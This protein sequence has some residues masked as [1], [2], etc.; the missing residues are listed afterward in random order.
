[1]DLLNKRFSCEHCV[2][3][4]AEAQHKMS[5][6]HHGRKLGFVAGFMA[7]RFEFASE[8]LPHLVSSKAAVGL[9]IVTS[10]TV[11]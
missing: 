9:H 5:E 3:R 6:K 1:M 10:S 7:A 4:M 8:T 11:P 2:L